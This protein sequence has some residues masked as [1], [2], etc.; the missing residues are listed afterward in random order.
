MTFWGAHPPP[1]KVA[2]N[3][4]IYLR[5]IIFI[6]WPMINQF[7]LQP[8]HDND[9]AW[10]C[11][12]GLRMKVHIW[13]GWNPVLFVKPV[14]TWN[15]PIKTVKWYITTLVVRCTIWPRFGLYYL[16]YCERFM[17]EYEI[18]TRRN[19]T[20]IYT[21]LKNQFIIYLLQNMLEKYI[22]KHYYYKELLTLHKQLQI[23]CIILVY[24]NPLYVVALQRPSQIICLWLKN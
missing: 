8:M 12:E 21:S 1:P 9:T 10:W 24:W 2:D 11:K 13:L 15:E 19:I 16:L 4:Q 18:L 5:W 17:D 6:Q 20:L 3:A 22:K 14:L 7:C 23:T